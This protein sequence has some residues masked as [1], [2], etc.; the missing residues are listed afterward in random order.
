MVMGIFEEKISVIVPVRNE[1]KKI[2]NCLDAI[3]NQTLQP[4]E[5]I[6]VDGHSTD[7]TVKKA[8]NYPVKILYED[9]RT[10]AG[11]CQVGLENATGEYVSYTDADCIPDRD[12][13]EKELAV[14]K[15]N[16]HAAGVG[17][18]IDNVSTGIWEETINEV[19]KTFLGSGRSIQGRQYQKEKSVTSISGCHSLY[20]KYMLNEIGGFNVKL[21]TCEDTE[22][23]KRLRAKGYSLIYTPET[24]VLHNHTR[25]AK[26]FA[27]RMFQYGCGRAQSRLF[28]IQL[29]LPLSI[30]VLVLLLFVFPIAFFLV[31]SLYC[32]ILLSF[33]L[34]ITAKNK[35]HHLLMTVPIIMIVQH[36][37]YSLGFWKGVLN[38][39]K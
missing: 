38:G 23:N 35:K 21:K 30:P 8:L 15:Q 39:G 33:T 19:S 14:L 2:V 37:A 9:F 10:R 7:D 6:V 31:I 16:K 13:L 32:F 3:I 5:I 17:C 12:W 27:K 28:D 18:V 20:K 1:G 25:G 22:I 4:H 34:L 11:A 26:L 24:K 29:L 36:L